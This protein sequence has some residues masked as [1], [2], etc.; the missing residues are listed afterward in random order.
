MFPLLLFKFHNISPPAHSR[1][2]KLAPP[3]LNPP[4]TFQPVILDSKQPLTS[5]HQG[6]RT[7]K[8]NNSTSSPFPF[9][10]HRRH[11]PRLGRLPS[12]AQN[13]A[14]IPPRPSLP[15]GQS[16]RRSS[17][18]H[19]R[20]LSPRPRPRRRR[21][22]EPNRIPGQRGTTSPSSSLL[23]HQ[24][25]QQLTQGSTS[26]RPS[27]SPRRTCPSTASPSP[28]PS[29]SRHRPPRA[30]PTS[31]STPASASASRS[32]FPKRKSCSRRWRR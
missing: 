19:Q 10:F 5:R 22:P 23:I 29:T 26:T 8:T 32:S 11:G 9:P 21:A 17:R 30:T 31:P 27:P 15:R 28:R 12:P 7:K 20:S 6:N 16:A 3:T 18:P 14:P 13:R 1:S 2:S 4:A 24:Q 25:V